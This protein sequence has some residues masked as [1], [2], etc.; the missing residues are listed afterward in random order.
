[1]IYYVGIQVFALLAWTSSSAGLGDL[2]LG[3]QV[4]QAPASSSGTSLADL[5]QLARRGAGARLVVRYWTVVEG[6]MR[7]Q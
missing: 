1:M 3:A 6:R 4:R 5:A 2:A 7:W